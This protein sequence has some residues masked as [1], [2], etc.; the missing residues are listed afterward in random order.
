[1]RRKRPAILAYDKAAATGDA[2]AGDVFAQLDAIE[3]ALSAAGWDAER[4][5]VTLDLE[6]AR[7]EIRGAGVVFNLVESLDGVDRLQTAFVMALEEW[8][9]PFTGTGSAAMFLSN[10]KLLS[11]RLL[12]HNGLPVADCCRLDARGEAVW[13]PDSAAADGRPDRWIVKPVAAHAS[14]GITDASVVAA[15]GTE[16][17]PGA[18][19]N[20]RIRCG[21]DCFAERYI[22]GR[23]FNLSLIEAGGGARVLPPAELVFRDYPDGKPRIAGYAAKWDENSGEYAKTVRSFTAAENEP[24]LADALGRLAR[25]TW[26]A[27]DLSGYARVD[28]RVDRDGRPWILE[29]NANPCLAPDAGFAA[30]AEREG[31]DFPELCNLLVAAALD[32]RLLTEVLQSGD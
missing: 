1:M 25:R 29:V 17:I 8:G 30:A 4:A 7:D 13:F 27:F 14:L 20:A 2:A 11:K 16:D 5:A 24:E 26:D 31:W 15:T 22:D 6:A 19:R 21:T 9:I 12:A 32:R 23:E 10:D 3:T 18:I 28:F